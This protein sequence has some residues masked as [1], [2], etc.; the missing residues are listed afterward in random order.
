MHSGWQVDDGHGGMK[1]WVEEQL[2]FECLLL[3]M[4]SEKG[5][6]VGRLSEFVFV[7]NLHLLAKAT[8]GDLCASQHLIACYSLIRQSS[9][10]DAAR[11]WPGMERRAF[12]TCCCVVL[13]LL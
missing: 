6:G 12:S 2:A 13:N 5:G 9:T 11:S 8:W 10:L 1:G 3:S 4:G 7:L